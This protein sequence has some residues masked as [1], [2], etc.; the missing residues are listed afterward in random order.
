VAVL[1]LHGQ[2]GSA[3]DWD[4]VV[5]A[6][7]NR[8]RPVVITR[9][10]W[11]GRTRTS[12]LEGNAEAAVRALDLAQVPRAVVV[13]HSLGGAV[14]AWLA[15]ARPERVAALVLVAPSANREALVP[16][17]HLLASPLVGDAL[18]AAAL[19]LGGTV[20]AVGGLRRLVARELGVKDSYLQGWT[21]MLASPRTW[22]SF[23]A[24]QRMLIGE[25]P[26]LEGRLADIRAPTTV[27][28]GTADRIVP[29]RS[30]RRLVE[31]IP[32][33]R[34]VALRGA[35]HLVHQQ[36]PDQLAQI[37]LSV[38]G[39]GV[40]SSGPGSGTAGVAGSCGAGTVAGSS[41]SAGV[42]GSGTAGETGAS[43]TT[44]VGGS[45]G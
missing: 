25:L 37:I 19:A 21:T 40:G 30:A 41:G 9:P 1:L 42:P 11:D 38:S 26:Q 29:I 31:Q 28:A 15:A 4:A 44:G 33:A 12:T 17:D 13:G 34:L 45:P 7:S 32:G 27:V 16:A 43:G 14:A 23:V 3:R 6:L 8:A 24:E 22:R 10:G 2:P 18:G 36:R 5:A 35:H 20:L 39:S